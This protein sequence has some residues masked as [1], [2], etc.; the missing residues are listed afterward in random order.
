M[1]LPAL[2]TTN[3]IATC[4]C[5]TVLRQESGIKYLPLIVWV[6]QFGTF[7]VLTVSVLYQYLQVCRCTVRKLFKIRSEALSVLQTGW[8]TRM[9]NKWILGVEELR[10]ELQRRRCHRLVIHVCYSSLNSSDSACV[11]RARRS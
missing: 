6:V 1:L 4:V 9:Q 5:D 8:L 2:A 10:R 7:W 3:N 11:F